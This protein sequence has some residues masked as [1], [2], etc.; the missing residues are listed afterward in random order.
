MLLLLTVL[1][2]LGALGLF[3]LE[4]VVEL[5]LSLVLE[6]ALKRKTVVALVRAL[7]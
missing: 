1:A 5:V 3:A 6:L 4:T 7:G 2:L